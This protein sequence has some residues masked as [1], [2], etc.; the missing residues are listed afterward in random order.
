MSNSEERE[1]VKTGEVTA[2]KKAVLYDFRVPKKFTKEDVKALN[3]ITDAFLKHLSTGLTSMTRENCSVYNP[4]IEE[5]RTTAYLESLPKF[6]MIGL[7]GFTVIDTEFRDPMV[8]FHVPPSLSYLLIDILQ[9]GPGKVI[10]MDRQHTDIEIA[11][12]KNLITKFCDMLSASWSSLVTT[13]IS[14]EKSETNPKL[15]DV[16]SES[17]VRLVMSFDVSVKNSVSTISI[18]YSAQFLEDL[19]EKLHGQ[20]VDTQNFEPIDAERDQRR[21]EQIIDTLSESSIELKAIFAELTL[22]MQEVMSL[23]VGDIIPLDKKLTDDIT[24]EVDHVPWFRAKL[25]QT[26]IKKAVKITESIYESN[27]E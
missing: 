3:R 5:I 16:R 25:G 4:R 24:I 10:E 23:K 21:R 26:N 7:L 18:A 17:D 27:N 9:G 8:M 19:M 20:K 11:I 14:Y 12:L 22:D 15:I 6:T 1:Q 13:E 2:A